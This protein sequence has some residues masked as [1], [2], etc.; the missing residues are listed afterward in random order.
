MKY[1]IL[2]VAK[3]A[4]AN[5]LY[6]LIES[7]TQNVFHGHSL[8]TLKHKLYQTKD[9]IFI[10]GIR[11]PL[12]RN[13][14]YFFQTY[15]NDF[16]NDVKTK[17]NNYKGEYCYIMAKDDIYQ[18]TIEQLIKKF[19]DLDCHNTFNDWFN[20]FLEITQ[21]DSFD[22]ERGYDIYKFPNNNTI[23]IYTVEKL[24]DNK[25]ELCK[26]LGMDEDKFLNANDH[27]IRYYKNIYRDFK[28]QIRFSD[29]YKDKLLN[30]KVMKIFYSDGDIDEFF[31]QYT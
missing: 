27:E 1:Y 13:V 10:V 21:I 20:E 29:D 18:Y 25:H 3:V 9:N 31:S 11:N 16:H 4:S 26:I 17:V 14:S 19:M 7:G 12:E 28:S 6:A 15:H 2:T 23:I 5:F 22:K 30:T 24:N 8:L